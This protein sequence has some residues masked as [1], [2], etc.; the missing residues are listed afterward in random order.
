MTNYQAQAYAILAMGRLGLPLE[1]ITAVDTEMFIMFDKYTEKQATDL[2]VMTMDKRR[3]LDRLASIAAQGLR[4][5]VIEL[6]LI[7]S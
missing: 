7:Q 1:V 5:N 3:E 6:K 4:D 2:V